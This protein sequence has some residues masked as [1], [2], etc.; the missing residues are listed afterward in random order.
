MR[1]REKDYKSFVPGYREVK[2][3]CAE[4]LSEVLVQELNYSIMTGSP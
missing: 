1:F 3:A 4:P 2:L